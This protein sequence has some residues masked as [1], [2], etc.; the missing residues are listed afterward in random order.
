MEAEKKT[1]LMSYVFSMKKEIKQFSQKCI[2]RQKK[3]KAEDHPDHNQLDGWGEY[4][5][6]LG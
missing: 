1:L 4:A 2:K 3:K 6:C 5:E